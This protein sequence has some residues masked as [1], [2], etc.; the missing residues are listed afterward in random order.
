MDKVLLGMSG[1]VDSTA[2]VLLLQ[3]EGYKVEGLTLWLHGTDTGVK[4]A[5]D[6][7]AH[8]GIPHHA[9]D[10]RGEFEETVQ[11]PFRK[12]YMEGK[13]PNPCVLCN[14]E[15]KFAA[16]LRYAD[17]LGIPYIAT[18]HYAAL[19]EKDGKVFLKTAADTK[20][21][22][23]YFLSQVPSALLPRLL[24]PLGAYTKE[25]VRILAAEKGLAAAGKRDSQEI[26]FIPDNDYI[27]YLESS[28]GF[29]AKEGKILDENGYVVG[30]HQGVH[31][32]TVG[33]RK[34]L[35]AFGKKVFV[36]KVCGE[37]N[38]VTIGENASLFCRGLVAEKINAF[39]VPEGEVLVK[40]RSGAPAAPAVCHMEDGKLFVTFLEPQR[41]V[42]PG[43][44]VAVYREDILLAGGIIL[45]PVF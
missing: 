14:T 10:M 33:Q 32:Y 41:A 13:T 3:K 42:T 43:Q 31:R 9:L 5:A 34:G 45:S 37:E 7:A 12:A 6:A 23:T 25:E 35:G 26:C 30:F 21:D 18:G 27:A 24:L 29:S 4:E 8:L 16:L 1:G 38:T 11:A 17:A 22:Q 19:T 20:K 15:I 36:T 2:A 39:A 28:P 44:T 40:I